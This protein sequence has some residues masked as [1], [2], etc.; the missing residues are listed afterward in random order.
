M[1]KTMNTISE[2][3]EQQARLATQARAK[4]DEITDDTDESRA[5]EIEAEFDRMMADHD[6]LT[7]KIERLQRLEA[8]EERA[9]EGD[10]RRPRGE[11]G[12]GR[13][14]KPKEIAYGDVFEKAV[15]F[16]MSEL[17]SEERAVLMTGRTTL[18]EGR[19]QTSTTGSSGAYT[20]PEGFS[21]ELDKALAL[22]GPMWDANIV[23]E[24]N[25]SS[26]NKLPWPTVDDTSKTGELH[27]ENGAATD[28][29][30]ADVVFG[31]KELDA[32]VYDTE[33][34]RIPIELLQ[35]SAFNMESLLSDLFGER[36][37]RKANAVLTTGTGSSQPDGIVTAS[38]AGNTA[39]SATT[40]D[41]DELLDLLHKVDPAYRGSPKVRWMF[42]DATLAAI[43]KLKDGNGNYLWQM[44]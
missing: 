23:R 26:G 34:V 16:G 32:Y 9:N 17:S 19:A 28:D 1:E 44:G 35:D 10:P 11:D 42:N 40:L 39:A 15:R 43:R 20:V 8:A 30:G 36:L 2:L 24:L 37:G 13:Q 21:G 29:G 18:P 12:E 14:D 33:M 4:F 22:W 5:G 41:S 27:T 3:R 38:G 25:T 7:P 31:Q 6:A